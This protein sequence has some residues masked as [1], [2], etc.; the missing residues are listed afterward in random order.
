MSTINP[1][2]SAAL[3]TTTKAFEAEQ[4]P[5]PLRVGLAEDQ[6]EVRL[7]QQLRYRIFAGEHGARL[8]NTEAGVDSDR[9]DAH[10]EHLIVRRADTGEVVGSTRILTS[11]GAARAGGFYS[12][13]EFDLSGILPLPGNAIEI[14][15]TCIHPEYRSGAGIGMLWLGLARFMEKKCVKFLFGCASIAMGDNGAQATAIMQEARA[16]H[17]SPANLRVNPKLPLL[18]TQPA[19]RAQMPP[20]LKA[21][22]RL[23]CWVAGEPCYDPDFDV[24]DVFIMLDVANLNVRYHRHFVEGSLRRGMADPNLLLAA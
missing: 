18:P 22:L 4:M 23:G 13:N 2:M 12:E 21:Y 1:A 5:P 15:R 24:A 17:L 7:S 14:G 3:R 9:Y 6:G 11:K 10:C 19:E 16:R 8:H 20:L